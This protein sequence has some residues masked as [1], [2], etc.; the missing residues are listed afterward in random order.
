MVPFPLRVGID[1]VM[2][3]LTKHTSNESLGLKF[4]IQMFSK[5]SQ[6]YGK[7]KS[8]HFHIF[9]GLGAISMTKLPQNGGPCIKVQRE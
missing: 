6:R 5:A 2:E 1:L 9:L 3:N 8:R 7:L 4:D